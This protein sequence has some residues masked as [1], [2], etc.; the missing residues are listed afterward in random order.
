MRNTIFVRTRDELK[1]AVGIERAQIVITDAALASKIRLVAKAPK[2]A[3]A[4]ALVAAGASVGMAW[5]PLG[6]GM[7]AVST[8]VAGPLVAAVAFFLVSLGVG[9]LYSIRKNY[10]ITNK[11]T[12]TMPDGTVLENATVMEPTR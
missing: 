3:L 6:W 1:A 4:A 10:K 8:A 5:N 9:H 7:A 12:V 11:T 2:A